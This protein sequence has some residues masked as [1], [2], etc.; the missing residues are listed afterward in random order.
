MRQERGTI[1]VMTIGFLVFL[2]L[3]VVVVVNS[4]AAFLQRQQLDNV[5]DGAARAA[6][7][8]LSTD[9][10]YRTGAITLNG[11]AARRLVGDYVRGPGVRV[12]QVRADAN[13]V[14][15]RLERSVTL[16]IAPPGWNPRTTIV[17]EATA[18]L[19]PTP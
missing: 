8:G 15:V 4:S 9:T 17:S 10:F 12:V 1:T 7:D 6:A 2:G 13:Q 18:Q 11:S 3:L 19:R 14:L 16:A 5:A